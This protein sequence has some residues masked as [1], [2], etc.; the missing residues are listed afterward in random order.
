MLES[1]ALFPERTHVVGA[2][3]L[4]KA[5]RVIAVLRDLGWDEPIYLHG[6]LMPM[7]GLYSGLGVDLGEL[8]LATVAD[9]RSWPARSCWRRRRQSRTAGRGG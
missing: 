6:A 7:C 9:G 3:A 1:L 2:Y 4:G 8:R 5:Q